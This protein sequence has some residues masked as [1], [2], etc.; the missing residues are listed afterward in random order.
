MAEVLPWAVLKLP[1]S[2]SWPGWVVGSWSRPWAGSLGLVYSSQI[3]PQRWS[4]SRFPSRFWNKRWY[5][6]K[7]HWRGAALQS[8]LYYIFIGKM[9][10]KFQK[11]FPSSTNVSM[12]WRPLKLVPLHWAIVNFI[13]PCARQDNSYLVGAKGDMG[14]FRTCPPV[15]ET[16]NNPREMIHTYIKNLTIYVDVRWHAQMSGR[17][18]WITEHWRRKAVC[19]VAKR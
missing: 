4:P 6:R 2:R 5:K 12:C 14:K 19:H 17:Q 10:S 18:K 1:S 3:Q 15:Q 7:Q 8:H 13:C 11:N 9:R 16:Y